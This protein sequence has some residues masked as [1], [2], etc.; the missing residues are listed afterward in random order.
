VAVGIDRLI[1]PETH[2]EPTKK[3]S[4]KKSP[5]KRA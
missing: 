3:V 2:D 1:V 4:S 5:R